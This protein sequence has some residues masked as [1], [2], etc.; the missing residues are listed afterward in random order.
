M[1]LPFSFALKF[2]C[3]RPQGSV[4]VT[5]GTFP[6]NC[7]LEHSDNHNSVARISVELKYLESSLKTKHK[8]VL[9]TT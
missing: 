6:L 3:S 1:A 5:G 7:L 2:I 4:A 9:E 8:H